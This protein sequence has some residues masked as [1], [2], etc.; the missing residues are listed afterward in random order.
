[1]RK[2]ERLRKRTIRRINAEYDGGDITFEMYTAVRLAMRA[3]R[4]ERQMDR[5]LLGIELTVHEYRKRLEYYIA[6]EVAK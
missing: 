1:M 4:E 2:M 6:M 3:L 5:E